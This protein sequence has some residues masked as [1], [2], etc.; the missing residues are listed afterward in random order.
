MTNTC[1]SRAA[2]CL[3]RRVVAAADSPATGAI[4][5]V[6]RMDDLPAPSAQVNSRFINSVIFS[7]HTF[8]ES[9]WITGRPVRPPECEIK[10]PVPFKIRRTVADQLQSRRDG[11]PLFSEEIPQA[12]QF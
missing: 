2:S 7:P 1:A 10:S 11:P 4:F 8:P 3:K 12:R 5:M 6:N 9:I